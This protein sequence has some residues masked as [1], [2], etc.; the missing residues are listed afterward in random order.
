MPTSSSIN[1]GIS[2][3]IGIVQ[4]TAIG[5]CEKYFLCYRNQKIFY[6]KIEEIK[7]GREKAEKI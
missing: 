5:N 3:D 1:N 7:K 6:Y 4:N 2:L